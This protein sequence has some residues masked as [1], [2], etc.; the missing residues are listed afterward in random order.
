VRRLGAAL[1]GALVAAGCAHARGVP[2]VAVRGGAQC[3]GAGATPTA[4]WIPSEAAARQ[5]LGLGAVLD[6]PP[7]ASLGVD[8]GRDGAVLVAMGRRPT[9]GYEIALASPRAEV[10]DGVAT[11]AVRFEE[12]PQGAVLAQV[13][14]SPCL[15]VVLPRE[16]LREV[17]VVDGS[18]AVR[19]VA[20][21]AP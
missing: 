15:L 9:A 7:P 11:I 14:T 6:G 12:P 13:V 21:V 2:A 1:A 19:A 4:R 18:G 10:K 8:F 17:R 20:P 3:G 5:A 16:G